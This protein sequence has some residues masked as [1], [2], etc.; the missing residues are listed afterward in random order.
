[1]AI[2]GLVVRQHSVRV[3]D[4]VVLGCYESGWRMQ[5]HMEVYLWRP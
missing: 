1:M 4:D 5:A 2:L 3:Q